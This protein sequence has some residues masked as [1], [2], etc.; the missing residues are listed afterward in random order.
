MENHACGEN[1][2][3]IA[4]RYILELAAKVRQISFSDHIWDGDT[5]VGHSS[6]E[7]SGS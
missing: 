4:L 6:A 7:S 5:R 3:R 1:M 2:G